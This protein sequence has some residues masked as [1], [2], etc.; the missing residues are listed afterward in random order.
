MRLLVN[1]RVAAT[2]AVGNVVAEGV[3]LR[4]LELFVAE[5]RV[6]LLG[7]GVIGLEDGDDDF[8]DATLAECKGE[9]VMEALSLF[10]V[11]EGT[12]VVL[13]LSDK[14][15]NSDGVLEILIT[16]TALVDDRV[17]VAL[18]NAVTLN[19]GLS[20]WE[21]MC[22]GVGVSLKVSLLVSAVAVTKVV[23]EGDRD[24]ESDADDELLIVCALV[25]VLILDSDK[26]L[27]KLTSTVSVSVEVAVVV[28]LRLE[29]LV[30]ERTEMDLLD[31]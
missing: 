9:R 5:R 8:D 1:V 26:E 22:D 25:T 11:R 18:V 6:V 27:V 10:L 29:E 19:S 3:A 2:V 24:A 4:L 17:S 30:A 28:L 21:D 12:G 20:V 23:N 16:V 13:P 31:V 14:E 7:E 15:N